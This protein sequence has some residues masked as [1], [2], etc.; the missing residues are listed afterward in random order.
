M[1][2]SLKV[3]PNSR[4]NSVKE[5]ENGIFE[6]KVSV[7]PEKGKANE[8][9]IELVAKHLKIPKTKIEIISGLSSKQKIM[10]INL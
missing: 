8:R 4:E 5:L 2:I 6:V 1:K 3:K 7:P 10:E 9:V